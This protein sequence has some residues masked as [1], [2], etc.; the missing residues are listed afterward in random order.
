VAPGIGVGD[1][2]ITPAVLGGTPDKPGSASWVVVAEGTLTNQLDIPVAVASLD[3]ILIIGERARIVEGLDQPV[4]IE[5]GA[6]VS[7]RAVTDAGSQAPDGVTALVGE[8][9]WLTDA[10]R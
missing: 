8:W 5:A 10:C 9:H 2:E 4:E 3:V 1:I 6:T 7:W